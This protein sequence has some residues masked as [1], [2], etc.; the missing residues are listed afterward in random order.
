MLQGY[1]RALNEAPPSVG[2]IDT[3]SVAK[4]PTEGSTP[5]VLD[6]CSHIVL[7]TLEISSAHSL[8]TNFLSMPNYVHKTH[9][10]LKRS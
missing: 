9:L 6:F 10:S 4:T 7:S 1:H 5:N 3:I 8:K 2:L